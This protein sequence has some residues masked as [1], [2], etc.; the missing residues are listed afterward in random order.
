M[1]P[2]DILAEYHAGHDCA[3]C[4]CICECGCDVWIGC[5][6]LGGGMCSVCM[7]REQRDEGDGP[8][9]TPSEVSDG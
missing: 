7:I 3:P 9:R 2:R 8:H 5:T 4:K 1:P 6:A